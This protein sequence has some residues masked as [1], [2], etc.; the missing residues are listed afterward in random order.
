[1]AKVSG[2]L[3]HISQEWNELKTANSDKANIVAVWLDIANIYGSVPH[4]LIF[5]AFGQ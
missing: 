2:C 3:E 5:F 1:M 4:Q